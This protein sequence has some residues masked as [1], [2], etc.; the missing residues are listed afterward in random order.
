M[1]EVVFPFDDKLNADRVLEEW[2]TVCKSLGTEGFLLFGTCL[3]IVRDGGYIKGDWDID[4]GIHREFFPQLYDMLIDRGFIS[5]DKKETYQPVEKVIAG[6][7]CKF[8]KYNI[9]LDVWIGLF[10]DPNKT[11]LESFDKATYEGREYNV[12]HPV[13]EY[14]KFRYGESWRVPDQK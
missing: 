6:T 3:G 12:P 11:Y 8:I 4:V 13:Q 2:D 9:A 10:H 5:P 1:V 7:H 14:L